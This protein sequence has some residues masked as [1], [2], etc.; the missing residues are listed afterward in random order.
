[1]AFGDEISFS[2]WN[3]NIEIQNIPDCHNSDTSDFDDCE[4]ICCYDR[5]YTTNNSLISNFSQNT[6]KKYKIIISFFD[7]W[8][9]DSLVFDWNFIWDTSP[10][11]PTISFK[12]QENIYIKLVW[13]TKSN[14]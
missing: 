4:S 2:M 13:K 9:I 8:V 5:D 11:D 6:I 3:H 12:I 14:T 7:I 10:P 1:M